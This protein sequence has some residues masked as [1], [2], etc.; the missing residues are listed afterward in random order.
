[1]KLIVLK[2]N[3]VD[4][5]NAIE[6]SVGNNINLPILKNIL[7]SVENNKIILTST[8]LETAV[9]YNLSGK[10]V[11]GGSLTVP[12]GVF[13]NIAKNINSERV[14]LESQDNNS[15]LITTDNYEASVRVQDAKDFPII[16]TIQNKDNLIKT[17]TS[18]IKEILSRAIIAAQYSDVRPEISGV[19]LRLNEGK[20]NFVATDSFR[21]VEISLKAQEFETNLKDIS[22]IIPLRTANELLR[23]LSIKDGGEI[24]IFVD[25]NQVL[26]QTETE[27]LIS[28][29]IDGTFPDY[30]TVIPKTTKSEAAIAR[31]ELINAVKVTKVFAGRANDVTLRVGD[32]K[33]FI[34]VTAADSAIGE[35]RYKIPIRLKGEKFS[36]SFNW[37][38]LAD[39]LK[40][41][42]GEEI[43]LGVNDPDRPVIIKSP[44]EPEMLYVV[45]PIKS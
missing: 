9:K 43:T 14:T 35:N 8:N 5:L 12:F 15:L 34:E 11:E 21:L 3:L 1:M 13:N 17:N 36:L 26:F 42:N 37:R 44:S 41:W 6:G 20:I 19:L 38:Y 32:N 45:M 16:P 4:A 28:R 31:D 7:F 18:S 25:P 30:Q 10:I 29:L 22:I 27:S 33:K 40:I 39:G 23:I 2:N 24:K